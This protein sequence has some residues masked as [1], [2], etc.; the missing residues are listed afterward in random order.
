M[1]RSL[2]LALTVLA[3][4]SMSLVAWH[5]PGLEKDQDEFSGTLACDVTKEGRQVD[6]DH[7]VY[8]I[9][10][11]LSCTLT[12]ADEHVAGAMSVRY[13]KPHYKHSGQEHTQWVRIHLDAGAIQWVGWAWGTVAKNGDLTL[14]NGWLYTPEQGAYYRHI[15]WLS[16]DMPNLYGSYE[17]RTGE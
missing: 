5:K 3:V 14:V 9:D 11:E 1:K 7:F 8:N 15:A 6:Q 17:T 16:F 4:I 2:Y 10:R 13:L 12:S